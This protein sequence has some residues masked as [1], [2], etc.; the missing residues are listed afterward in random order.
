MVKMVEAVVKFFVLGL[1]LSYFASY[2]S[3]FIKLNWI[4]IMKKNKYKEKLAFLMLL[5]ITPV[6]FAA[7]DKSFFDTI[8]DMIK[9]S[10]SAGKLVLVLSLLIGV[11]LIVMGLM[12]IRA[13]RDGGHSR[14]GGWAMVI[15]GF[16]LCALGWLVGGGTELLSGERVNIEDIRNNPYG[17]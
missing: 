13:G 3:K 14:G 12:R 2:G 10:D 4:N 5:L 9:L 7:G 1:L 17:D 6:V 11:V 8:D 15:I 16:L